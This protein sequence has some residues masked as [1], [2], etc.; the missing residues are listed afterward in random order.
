MGFV[1]HPGG[2]G[3]PAHPAIMM[4][5]MNVMMSALR[6]SDVVRASGKINAT[7]AS[8]VIIA[9]KIDL[10]AW[11]ANSPIDGLSPAS[12]RTPPAGSGAGSGWFA[13]CWSS[14]Q[15]ASLDVPGRCTTPS[16]SR[17]LA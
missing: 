4:T 9:V 3:K 6:T 14:S 17:A 7:A 8:P 10:T 5:T 16:P 12:R 15:R 2:V 1:W 11:T 13:A